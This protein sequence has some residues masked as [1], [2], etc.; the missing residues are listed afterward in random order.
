MT[1]DDL[2]LL[3]QVCPTLV[4][5]L[6]SEYY[7][8]CAGLKLPA[9]AARLVEMAKERDEAVEL[10]NIK[11]TQRNWE[12]DLARRKLNDKINSARQKEAEKC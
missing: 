4:K 7:M 2:D 1:A 12:W 10:L 9:I 3:E 11:P 8:D 6:D 5:M